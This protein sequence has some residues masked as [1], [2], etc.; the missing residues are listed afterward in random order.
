MGKWRPDRDGKAWGYWPGAWSA[1]QQAPW[2]G[3]PSQGSGI[4]AYDAQR[5]G[6]DD[7]SLSTGNEDAPTLTEPGL[8]QDLQKAVNTARRTE[9]RVK[10]IQQEK[11]LK[12]QQ[13]KSWE[14]D[15][16]RSYA[17]EKARYTAALERLEADMQQALQ[18]QEQAR[19]AVRQV[20][21]GAQDVE[22][23][24]VRLDADREFDALMNAS[25]VDPWDGE[26]QSQDAVLRRALAET[27]NQGQI[28]G[29]HD[30]AVRAITTPLRP[31]NATPRTP[32]QDKPLATQRRVA[33][34]G[35]VQGL[36]SSAAA[37]SRL[38]PFPP[39]TKA[40]GSQSCS[41]GQPPPE[42]ATA[43]PY[44]FKTL[45]ELLPVQSK[46]SPLGGT[47]TSP[48]NGLPKTP[49]GRQSVKDAAKPTKPVRSLGA[50]TSREALLEQK[51][52]AATQHLDMM[53]GE[54]DQYHD[55]GK[56]PTVVRFSLSYDDDDPGGQT[57]ALVEEG[58]MD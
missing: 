6:K 42:L 32:A 38:V 47:L 50:H 52:S 46:G 26:D 29:A 41:E 7:K 27:M 36:V 19:I 1:S 44:V 49:K 8:L 55:D 22:V 18:A 23:S 51:R 39:P 5:S 2:R 43:D 28:F 37:S 24:P 17:K 56:E 31:T 45:E 11:Q 3:N 14:A 40:S 54:V 30:P 57:S 33:P 25:P 16:K 15:L 53:T 21:C 35:Q 20:A 34:P 4:P 13:W 12:T 9:T 58:I 10:K 48:A